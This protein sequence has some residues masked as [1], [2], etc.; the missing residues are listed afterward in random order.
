MK[1][2]NDNIQ[3]RTRDLPTCSASTN[4]ATRCPPCVCVCTWIYIYIYIYIC[5]CVVRC[6]NK[7]TRFFSN[8]VSWKTVESPYCNSTQKTSVA[9]PFVAFHKAGSCGLVAS[10]HTL[11]KCTATLTLFTQPYIHVQARSHPSLQLR[12]KC[13]DWLLLKSDLFLYQVIHLVN[14]YIY[15]YIYILAVIFKHTA[16]LELHTGYYKWHCIV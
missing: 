1:N 10:F 7:S 12:N 16:Y 15:I 14:L 3:N 5:V 13:H 6:N 11:N 2:S 9:N 4:E 8:R